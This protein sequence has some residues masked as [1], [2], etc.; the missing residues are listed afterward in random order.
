MVIV[1]GDLIADLALHIP[2]F[3]IQAQDLKPISYLEIGPGGATNIAIMAA[4]FGLAVACLGEVGRD[5]FGAV[6]LN[7]LQR[8]G[9][10]TGN[11]VVTLE[12]K[13]PVAGVIVDQRREPAYL[14]Y[15]GNLVVRTLPEAWRAPLETA[16]ALF[17]DGWVE[18]AEMPRLVLDAFR[19]AKNAGVKIF[20]DP[21]PGNPAF[22]NS[23]H[24]E[25]AA[26]ANVL[27]VNEHE[28]QVLA[29]VEDPLAAAGALVKNG[30]ELVVLKRGA[31]GL[32]LC[33]ADT[34]EAVAGFHVDARDLTGAGDSVTGAMLYGVLKGLDHRALGILG[35]A[36]GATKVQKL[37]TGHNMPTLE[38]IRAT[39]KR[40][41]PEA[42][43]LIG[44][45]GST[46]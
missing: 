32:V 31:A 18:I 42:V 46:G 25:A 44:H 15:R 34:Q 6:V 7:G 9:I 38:E 29:A 36:T 22:D 12:S 28:A 4:R 16:Q 26:R 37:G 41:A 35:N 1:L 33:S 40:F 10:D 39:L 2:D 21:G 3:P 30:S 11:V 5:S 8:E 17:A 45:E 14:G 20:F 23:W 27:L 24:R 19:I 43:D 13:T